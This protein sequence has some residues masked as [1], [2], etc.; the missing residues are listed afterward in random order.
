[1]LGESRSSRAQRLIF[2][3]DGAVSNESELLRGIAERLGEA[4]L[5]TIGIGNAPNAYLMRKMAWFGR[6]LCEFVSSG[7]ETG[8]RIDAFFERLDR[9]V[10]TDLEL[11]WDGIEVDQVYP[12]R[13]PDLHAGQPLVL[14]ARLG[15]DAGSGK[16]TLGGRTR[17]GWI[18]TSA[19]MQQATPG[20]GVATRWARA[21]V[22][23]L[24]D[25]LQEGAAKEDVR[26]EVIDVG[27][28]FNL[29]TAFTSLVAVEEVPTALGPS[30]PL[31]SAVAL[32]SGGTTGPLELRLGLLLSAL[33]LCL[34]ALRAV[35]RP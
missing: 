6:G 16:L 13:L 5:H 32:P 21:R 30:H 4:R 26:T 1:M 14:Y 3:T 17:A 9:P 25:S 27:L 31:R 10:M 28:D 29:V 11:R 35:R 33:G 8:N 22:D 34:F 23:W 12:T 15:S 7:D 20:P 2:L 18:E 19:S 24:M